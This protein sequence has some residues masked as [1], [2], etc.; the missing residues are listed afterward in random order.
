MERAGFMTCTA[1][2]H[3]GAI[4]EP[5]ASLFRTC[6]AHP[7]S[8]VQTNQ[9]NEWFSDQNSDFPLPTGSFSLI[10]KYSF[11]LFKSFNI[12]IFKNE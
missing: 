9:L 12:S 2:S 5:A 10:L 8:A 3:Q 4:K 6:E 7:E 1:A 11:M